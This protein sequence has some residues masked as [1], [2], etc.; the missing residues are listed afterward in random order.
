MP[1]D[2]HAWL[3]ETLERAAKARASDVHLVPGEPPRMRVAGDLVAIPGP[4]LEAPFVADLIQSVLPPSRRDRLSAGE[5]D[6]GYTDAAGRRHRVAAFRERRGRSIAFRLLGAAPPSLAALRMPGDIL[7]AIYA[8]RGLVLFAGA[9]GQGKT[10]TLASV[11]QE[12]CR[13]RAAHVITLEDPI[14]YAIEPGRAWLEQREVGLH[15]ASFE[16]GLRE[17]LASEPD[18]IAI[19]ELRD[20]ET[21]P[22]RSRP[23]SPASSSSRRCTRTT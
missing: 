8:S 12:L 7:R 15:C 21:M 13:R 4:R 22:S 11:L 23:P 14:E 16:A 17:A 10:T 5:V 3:E 20:I 19:G 18:V 2:E 6:F 1:A 9:A